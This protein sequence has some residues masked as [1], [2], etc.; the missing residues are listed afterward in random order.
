[1]FYR[2]NKIFI[3]TGKK[4]GA[5]RSNPPI[6]KV[7]V[8]PECTETSMRRAAVFTAVRFLFYVFLV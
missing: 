5:E 2:E 6:L 4:H 1:M 3:N 7:S 8:S